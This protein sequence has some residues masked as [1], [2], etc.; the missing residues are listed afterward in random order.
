MNL[1]F[2]FNKYLKYELRKTTY[3]KEHLFYQFLYVDHCIA[4]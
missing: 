3:R 4:K 2:K 1:L